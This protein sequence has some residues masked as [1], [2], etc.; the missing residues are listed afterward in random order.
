MWPDSI[1]RCSITCC[2][3]ATTER[4]WPCKTNVA[5]VSHINIVNIVVT[6]PPR[7]AGTDFLLQALGNRIYHSS[8]V[9][10]MELEVEMGVRFFRWFTAK[11]VKVSLD[12]FVCKA[13]HCFPEPWEWPF[14]AW[15]LEKLSGDVRREAWGM[16]LTPRLTTSLEPLV[17]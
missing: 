16:R 1:F 7:C 4:I 11:Q 15:E 5:A 17:S 12:L 3:I 9:T 10:F 6:L 2:A 14:Q 13:Q 8:N